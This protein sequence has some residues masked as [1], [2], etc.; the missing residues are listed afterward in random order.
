MTGNHDLVTVAPA[1]AASMAAHEV[2]IK[3]KQ[4]A[5]RA[6]DPAFAPTDREAGPVAQP[7]TVPPRRGGTARPSAAAPEEP[8]GRIGALVAWRKTATAPA[9]VLDVV[10]A[11]IRRGT[12]TSRTTVAK[13]EPSAVAAFFASTGLTRKQIAEAVG[14]STSVIGTVQKEEGDRWSLARFEAAKPLIVAAA[15]RLGAKAK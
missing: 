7:A 14:V 8:D 4:A 11:A 15:K 9:E 12:A 1:V 10:D 5:T 13:A 2:A 3:A 6:A